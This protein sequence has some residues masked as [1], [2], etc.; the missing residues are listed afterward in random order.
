MFHRLVLVLLFCL[1]SL[2]SRAA[3][4]ELD[5]LRVYDQAFAAAARAAQ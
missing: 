5:A 1:S 2:S 4:Q 3:G